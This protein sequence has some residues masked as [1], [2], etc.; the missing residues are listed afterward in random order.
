MDAT[1]ETEHPP[2]K[3][4][5]LLLPICQSPLSSKTKARMGVSCAT[6]IFN[7]TIGR[8]FTKSIS[9]IFSIGFRSANKIN[10][11]AF[12][13]AFASTKIGTCTGLSANKGTFILI[14]L[15]SN[16]YL[17]SCMILFKISSKVGDS[18]GL[19]A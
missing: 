12:L 16:I 7:D 5:I 8:R 14:F 10:L 17:S 6:F 18:T 3:L 9:I 2:P 19:F 15:S 13:I 11:L 4:L 1:L